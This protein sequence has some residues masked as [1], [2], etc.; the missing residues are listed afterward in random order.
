M[1]DELLATSEAARLLRVSE[2]TVRRWMDNGK[3]PVVRTASGWR[4]A[5]R[6]DVEELAR[7]LA[8]QRQQGRAAKR[9][10]AGE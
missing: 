5:R 9:G 4:L 10:G 1:A 7:E 6:M 3:L 8:Q 2:T